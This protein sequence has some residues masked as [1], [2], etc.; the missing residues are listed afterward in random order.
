MVFFRS[1]SFVLG[2][3][4]MMIIILGAATVAYLYHT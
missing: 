3:V 2:L 4:N 1:V